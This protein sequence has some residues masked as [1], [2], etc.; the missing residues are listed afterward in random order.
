MLRLQKRE[1]MRNVVSRRTALQTFATAISTAI[2]TLSLASA[3]DEASATKESN[4]PVTGMANPDL[5]PFDNLMTEFLQQHDVPGG[6]IAVTRN[7]QLIYARG[8][9]W[10][11]KETQRPV[12]PD[13]LFRLA[14]ISKPLTAVAVMQ[15]VQQGKFGLDDRV[16]DVLPA[17]DWLPEKHDERLRAITIKHLLQHSGGWD[18]EKSFDPIGRVRRIAKF[19]GKPL[20]ATPADVIRYTLSL[21][22]DFDPGTRY[23]YYNVDYL[24]LGRLIEHATGENYESYVKQHVLAPVGITRM[25]L[26]RAWKGDLA[27]GEVCY[28]DAEKQ[29]HKAINGSKLGELVPQVYGAENM[30]AYE[31]HG[32]WIGSAIDLTRFAAAFDKPDASPLLSAQS[33]QTMWSRP[34]G[35]PGFDSEG[36]PK[37]LYYGCGWSVRPVG[38]EGRANTFHSGLISGTSTLLVRRHDGLTWAV[39]FNT[40][41][42]Q[43]DKTL[44]SLIDPLLHEA[45]GAVKRW[46]DKAVSV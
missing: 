42:D 44:S 7:S 12:Q 27:Q 1:L 38:K 5:V 18:R 3:A 20:P 40:D 17:K 11:E 6:A 21:Q 14:S 4:L 30:E 29:E 25:Q 23:A 8:F 36:K 32:G 9:G 2:T 35:G 15:I 33:I 45:A 22:L 31:A 24:I 13:S 19:V 46:P 10:A 41:H 34:E 39:L 28:Y 43:K 37:D 26:G 16:F